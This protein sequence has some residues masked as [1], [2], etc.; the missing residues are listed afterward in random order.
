M[1]IKTKNGVLGQL[2]K[3]EAENEKIVFEEFE[4]E[5]SP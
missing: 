3:I 4:D 1:F 5:R 2:D